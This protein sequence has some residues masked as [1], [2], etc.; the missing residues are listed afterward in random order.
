MVVGRS[1]RRAGAGDLPAAAHPGRLRSSPGGAGGGVHPA[2]ARGGRARRRR[3][4]PRDRRGGRGGRGPRTRISGSS[5]SRNPS[6]YRSRTSRPRRRAGRRSGRSGPRTPSCA[7]TMGYVETF[8]NEPTVEPVEPVAEPVAVPAAVPVEPAP[9][10]SIPADEVRG[11]RVRRG[12]GPSRVAAGPA[13]R[14]GRSR[15]TPT[16]CSTTPRTRRRMPA[17]PR[18]SG[19][20]RRRPRRPPASPAGMPITADPA[21]LTRRS[22]GR[23]VELDVRT[24]SLNLIR[25]ALALLVLVAHGYYLSGVGTGPSFQGENLG[26]WAV[27]GFFTISGYLIT[28]SRFANPLGRYLVLRVR[29]DL[30]GLRGVPRRHGRRVRAGRVGRGRPRLGRLPHVADHAA[31]L[32]AGEP[33]AADQRL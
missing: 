21:S 14:A 27:F 3:R 13:P 15:G 33:R 26:G 10:E 8:A 4:D 2:G 19:S 6:P 5:T 11:V 1:R 28:A 7:T 22:G 16:R 29:P 9:A 30:P 31:G 23:T 17:R 20:R 12:V 24:N 25:L 32:R 18:T